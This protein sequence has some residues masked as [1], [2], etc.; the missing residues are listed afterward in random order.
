MKCIFTV[1][2]LAAIS[3]GF[4]GCAKQQRQETLSGSAR[5]AM[6]PSPSELFHL[7]SEC[8]ALGEKIPEWERMQYPQ[9][10]FSYQF[11]AAHYDAQAGDVTPR[12]NSRA[13]LASEVLSAAQ[14]GL[15]MLRAFPSTTV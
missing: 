3:I 7:R 9:V 5:A 10:H 8:L 6:M 15:Q 11:Q 2:A 4:L 12:L 14:L 1:A 13:Q